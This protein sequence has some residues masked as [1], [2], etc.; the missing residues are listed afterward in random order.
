MSV[1]SDLIAHAF[2]GHY[3]Y[4][5]QTDPQTLAALYHDDS[6]LNFEADAFE[7]G[8]G[9]MKKLVS[10]PAATYELANIDSQPSVNS[11][12]CILVEG[13]MLVNQESLH[14]FASF[15]L[16]PDASGESFWVLNQFFRIAYQS[17]K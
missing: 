17:G 10:L 2:C 16:M 7:G 5:L 4:A 14:F 13:Y 3:Y 6:M 8:D 1:E 11:G 12:V 9:I 15:Q